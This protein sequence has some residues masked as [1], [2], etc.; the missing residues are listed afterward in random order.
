MSRLLYFALAGAIV[1]LDQASK[2]WAWTTLR[3]QEEVDVIDGLLRF[4]YAENPGIAFSFFN[5][6]ATATRWLLVG[7]S[8]LAAT[9][10]TIY[11][12]RAEAGA[13]RLQGT[14]GLLLGGVVGNLVDRTMTGRVID[15]IDVYLGT[16]H[17]PTF[18]IADSAISVGAVLLAWEILT[19]DAHRP[20]DAPEGS[21]SGPV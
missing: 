8:A 21:K 7:A 2:W 19:A 1:A 3:G 18:N 12:L 9:V 15:F 14:L 10:V 6:G 16:Y 4:V 5:S 11:M 20:A 17:W 13:R